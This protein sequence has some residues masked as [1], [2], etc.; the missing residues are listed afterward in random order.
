MNC[1]SGDSDLGLKTLYNEDGFRFGFNVNLF[2]TTLWYCH[3]KWGNKYLSYNVFEA[4]PEYDC[5][6]TL[7]WQI[8]GDGLYYRCYDGNY[9]NLL[10]NPGSKRWA[11]D[12][13]APGDDT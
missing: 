4:E 11:W 10:S 3:F 6:G 9:A 2:S 13:T 5:R 7:Y 8:K 12:L 1:Q